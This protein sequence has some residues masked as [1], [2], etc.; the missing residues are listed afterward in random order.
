MGGNYSLSL[1]K[2]KSAL[3]NVEAVRANEVGEG[4]SNCWQP[5]CIHSSLIEV[6]AEE[7]SSDLHLRFAACSF[8]LH[9]R[10]GYR[11]TDAK[12]KY[13]LG[14]VLMMHYA[15]AVCPDAFSRVCSIAQR[16]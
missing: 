11:L 8:E 6:S 13:H 5:F 4:I 10:K 2:K 16:I 14:N 1:F 12:S 7:N 15:A 9:L 3:L